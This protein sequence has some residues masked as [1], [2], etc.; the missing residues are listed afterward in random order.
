VQTWTGVD[1]GHHSSFVTVLDA[2]GKTLLSTGFKSDHTGIHHLLAELG[3]FAPRRHSTMTIAVEDPHSMVTQALQA[4]NYTVIHVHPVTLARFRRSTTISGAKS[5]RGDSLALARIIQVEP[6]GHRRVPQA[7]RALEAL[8][9][10][11]R[12]HADCRSDLRAAEGRLWQTLSEF[13]PAALT[14]FTNLTCREA[15]VALRLAPSPASA[16]RMSSV[17]L[18]R[19]LRE[20]GRSR[21]L[22]HTTDVILSGLQARQLRRHPVVEHAYSE[23]LLSRLDQLELVLERRSHLLELA[24]RLAG[25]HP[26]WPVVS[27]FPALGQVTGAALL[28]EIGDDPERFGSSNGLLALAGVAPV[29]VASGTR[30]VVRRRH[31]HN[32]RLGAVVRAWSLPLI[33]HSPYARSLYD[34]RRAAGDKHAAACRRVLHRFLSGLNYCLR[35]GDPYNEAA[36]MAG[37]AFHEREVKPKIRKSKYEPL[38]EWLSRQTC[39][40]VTASFAQLEGLVGPLPASAYDHLAWW[41]GRDTDHSTQARSWLGSGYYVRSVNLQPRTVVFAPTVSAVDPAISPDLTT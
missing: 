6:A 26:L 13:Y 33:A 3:R 17:R 10:T 12:A 23:V 9:V 24:L 5:D 4:A 31:I 20:S 39:G 8:R 14:T 34:I 32:Q 35:T 38:R 40:L 16:R 18:R 7:S 30:H 25:D 21:G 37:R 28:A 27:S 11:T 2:T 22:T 15:R 36:L 29:T 1:L 19:A 41:L